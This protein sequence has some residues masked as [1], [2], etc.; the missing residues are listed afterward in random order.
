MSAIKWTNIL[1]S[2]ALTDWLHWRYNRTNKKGQ[3]WKRYYYHPWYQSIHPIE[4]DNL[5]VKFHPHLALLVFITLYLCPLLTMP[6]TPVT[7]ENVIWRNIVLSSSKKSE[8][9]TKQISL[10]S[11]V[12]EPV[13]ECACTSYHLVRQPNPDFTQN[14]VFFRYR[15]FFQINVI[16]FWHCYHIKV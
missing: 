15:F 5:S 14:L 7:V 11:L 12:T 9:Q 4:I 10:K 13:S 6:L 16:S 3:L 1:K 2:A 8:R